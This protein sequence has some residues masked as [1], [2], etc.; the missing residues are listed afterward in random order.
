[1]LAAHPSQPN[2]Q[3]TPAGVFTLPS[4]VGDFFRRRALSRGLSGHAGRI[5]RRTS[6]ALLAM[7]VPG[8]AHAVDTASLTIS[9]LRAFPTFAVAHSGQVLTKPDGTRWVIYA[10]AGLIWQVDAAGTVLDSGDIRLDA[11]PPVIRWEDRY[12]QPLALPWAFVSA[13]PTL[14]LAGL[15]DAILKHQLLR[16]VGPLPAGSTL[17]TDET[18][19]LPAEASSGKAGTL[20]S[21]RGA[22]V[23][24]T[25]G[26]TR[27]LI[28]VTKLAAAARGS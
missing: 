24:I 10:P 4:L 23:L 21:S 6:I 25:T 15:Y 26:Q 18:V 19:H 11:K 16:A 7:A 2:S 3:H 22:F 5:L 28:S 9:S 14:A 13:G 1:M 27:H 12:V 8:G 20:W 17:D